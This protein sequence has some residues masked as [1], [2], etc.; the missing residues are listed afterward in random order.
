M[1]KINNVKQL[2]RTSAH[3]KAMISNMITSL[4]QNE[5]IVT[6]KQKA[7][8]LQSFSEKIITRAKKNLTAT[9]ASALHN[10]REVMK[11]IKDRDAVAKLF[12]DIAKRV[13]DRNGGY[14]RI[15]LLG[16]KRAGDAAEKAIIELVD[17][18]AEEKN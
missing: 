2:G 1:R 15:Y 4:I 9:D 17:V 10:K 13:K 3:R 12:D 16:K 5:R 14:T 6:T 7:K 8:I 18:K 11:T